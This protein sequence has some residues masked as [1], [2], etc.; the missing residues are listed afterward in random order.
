MIKSIKY[1]SILVFLAIIFIPKLS[2]YNEYVKIFYD[3]DQYDLSMISL[4][5]S[6]QILQFL[7][8]KYDDTYRQW[9]KKKFDL[10]IL[11]IFIVATL[12]SL[13]FAYQSINDYYF[14]KKLTGK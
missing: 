10:I 12:I 6:V 5:F 8:W 9:I 7:R 14:L 1:Y 4:I 11:I 2:K 3:S 13:Y